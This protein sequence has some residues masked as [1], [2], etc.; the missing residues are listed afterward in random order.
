MNTVNLTHLKTIYKGCAPDGTKADPAKS[1]IVRFTQHDAHSHATLMSMLSPPF[2]HAQQN[3]DENITDQPSHISI[4]WP[5]TTDFKRKPSNQDSAYDA[6]V[7]FVENMLDPK[8]GAIV[9]IYHAPDMNYWQGEQWRHSQIWPFKQQW[10][11]KGKY[12]TIQKAEANMSKLRI[13]KVLD[14]QNLCLPIIRIYAKKCGYEIKYIDYTLT[15]KEF[16]DIMI[17][18]DYHFTYSGASMYTAAMIGIPCLAWHH[19]EPVESEIQEWRDYDNQEIIHSEPI[20]QTPWGNMST[21]NGKI[22]QYNFE[23]KRVETY[24]LRNNRHIEGLLDILKV[25][26]EMIK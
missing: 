14:Q 12:I 8:N 11:P 17:S 3:A 18:S 26:R 20:Q 2:L 10:N 23:K 15:T 1:Y 22:K 19:L 21:H 9:S 24:P 6:L 4:L 5:F 16:V 7:Y 13:N 25:F